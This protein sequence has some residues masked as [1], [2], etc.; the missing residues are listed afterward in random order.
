VDLGTIAFVTPEGE[1]TASV[2]DMMTVPPGAVHTFKNASA[3]EPAECYMTATP[4][5]FF[6]FTLL[7]M[8]D[9]D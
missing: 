4:G 7:V 5:E 2:G 9:G 6:P 8:A 3:T 1:V